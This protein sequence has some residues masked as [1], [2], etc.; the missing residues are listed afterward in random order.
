MPSPLPSLPSGLST[1][2]PYAETYKNQIA[3][4]V[5]QGQA[6]LSQLGVNPNQQQVTQ[7]AAA[8]ASLAQHGYNPASNS[9]NTKLITAIAGGASL[10]PGIGPVVGVTI[11]TLWAVGNAVACPVMK[12]MSGIFGGSNCN[13]PPCASSGNWTPQ[14][15]LSMS[16]LP[17]PR[18]MGPGTF[19]NFVIGALAQNAASAANCLPA[20]P[21]GL[22]VDACVNIWNQTHQ[23]PLAALYV[24]PLNSFG[25]DLIPTWPKT[26][27]NTPFDV[28]SNDADPNA[29]GAF[30]LVDALTAAVG[31]PPPYSAPKQVNESLFAPGDTSLQQLFGTSVARAVYVNNGPIIAQGL[32][33]V[34]TTLAVGAVGAAGLFAYAWWTKQNA[35]GVLRGLVG[36]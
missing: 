30:Q 23:G 32:D 31:Y 13:S 25:G 29:F 2:D 36:M 20:F 16:E 5:Q 22:V 8:A 34:T 24:P 33:P 15:V 10:I 21:P 35:L 18:L 19:A 27:G 1:L 26:S 28:A 3:S 7:G 14:I 12:V 9:D 4:E 11:L 17:P 6:Q